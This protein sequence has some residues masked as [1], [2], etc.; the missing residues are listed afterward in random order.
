VEG[1]IYIPA[2]NWGLMVAC[3]ALVLIFKSSSAL[4]AAYGFAL[5]G[6]VVIQT[7]LLDDLLLEGEMIWDEGELGGSYRCHDQYNEEDQEE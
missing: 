4:A 1:Q 5:S 2:L 7:E 3:I 6:D